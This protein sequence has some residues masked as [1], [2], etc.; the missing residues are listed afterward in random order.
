MGSKIKV[1]LLQNN[2]GEIVD[3]P[4][5]LSPEVFHDN[6]GFFYESWNMKKINKLLAKNISFDQDCISHS[7]KGVI[8][9]L[10]FQIPPYAQE[11]LV[12]CLSGEIFD[13]IVDLRNNSKTY[14]T[15][16]AIKL[17]ESEKKQLYVPKG[18]AHG[19]MALSKH[20]SVFYKISGEYSFLNQRSLKWNDNDL[21]IKWPLNK[22]K[23]IIS[24]KDMLAKNFKLIE[25]EL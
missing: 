15:Y 4:L 24:E 7:K 16:I 12:S 2:Q 22:V 5:I 25:Q 19:F 1:T 14:K 18:F 3:G 20:A 10:H 13:V 11:K 17:D 9:G 8:R 21:K 6:R 23:P